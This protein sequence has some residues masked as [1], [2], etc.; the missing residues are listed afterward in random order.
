MFSKLIAGSILALSLKTV[1]SA[2][3]QFAGINIAGFDFG[4]GTDV[5]ISSLHV[6][7]SALTDHEPQGTCVLSSVT[8]PLGVTGGDGPGQMAHFASVDKFNIFR[9]PVAWQ[10]LVNNVLGGPLDAGNAAEYDKLVQAC[11]ITGAHCIIDIHNYARWNGN[12]IGQPGGPKAEDFT[13][14]WGQL[15]TKYK[16]EEKVVMGLM[17]EP[18]D[19]MLLQSVF[20]ESPC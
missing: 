8:P 17:N 2:G 18:H 7:A 12:I 4:C 19:S 3:V 11:L 6:C 20:N 10:Y 14:L 1:S 15:A 16:A 5:A 9:L 13:G